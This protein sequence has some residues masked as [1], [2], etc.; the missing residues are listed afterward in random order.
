MWETILE[1]LQMLFFPGVVF[2]IILAF[3][4]EWYDRK[5]YAKIQS[6]VGPALA[7]PGGILQPLADL[8]KLFG[9]EDLTPNSANKFGFNIIPYLEVAISLYLLLFLPVIG[10]EGLISAP[11]DLIF[12]L[13][14][15][16]L[17]TVFIV[18]AGYF[19]GNRYSM[20]GSERAGVQFISYEVALFIT[21]ITPAIMARSLDIHEIVNYQIELIKKGTWWIYF[22]LL[23]P[24]F[25]IYVISALAKLEKPPFDAPEA[26]TELIA[27]WTLEYTGKKFGMFRFSNS[28][29]WVFLI[30]IGTAL[31]FAGP[32]LFEIPGI[33][34]E[35][36]YFVGF[37]IK[38]ILAAT[39]FTFLRSMFSRLRIDQ[40]RDF[41]WKYVTVAAILQLAFVITVITL[42]GE[43]L[44]I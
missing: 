24:A 26:E 40:I 11:G 44:G 16:A 14:V 35:V 17:F 41:F 13:F 28:L 33:P 31:F 10:V 27:G 37:I 5:L 8:L 43:M 32:F 3:F 34:V 20:I 22:L 7:G 25:I 42:W 6:R 15:S 1:I 12:L 4:V 23:L 30:G 9:K 36:S 2:F 19:S 29:Q 18:L 38:F 39:T 21:F